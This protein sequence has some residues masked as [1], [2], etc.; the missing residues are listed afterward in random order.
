[1]MFTVHDSTLGFEETVAALKESAEKNGW[2]ISMVHDLQ[3]TYQQAGLEDMSKV[4]TLYFCNPQGGYEI[5]QDDAYKP[6]AVMMPMGVSVY[7]TREGKVQIASMSL[8]R[9]SMMFGGVVKEVLRDGAEKYERALDDIAAAPE[10]C[11]E[12]QVDGGRCCLACAS[13]AA[14]VVALVGV[15]AVLMVKVFSRLMPKMMAKM[16]PNMMEMMEKEGVQ[17]PCAQII[18][19]RLEAQQGEDPVSE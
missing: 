5:L 8:E 17:P 18:L 4:T 6:M 15:A 2:E 13:L 14:G 10:P 12:T 16:M 7:E 1:M 11:E 9:M 3:K 19:E